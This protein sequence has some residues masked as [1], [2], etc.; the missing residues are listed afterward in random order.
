MIQILYACFSS[1]HRRWFGGGFDKLPDNRFL[2]HV[3]GFLACSFAL[4]LC[5]YG[6]LQIIACAGVLQGLFW[7]RAIGPALDIGRC[8]ENS[9]DT[10]ERYKKEW[11]NKICEFM[12]PEK[13]WY[14]LFYDFLWMMFRYSASSIIISIILLN[15]IFL[16]APV[17]ISII[18]SISWALY[19]KGIVKNMQAKDFAEYISG[20]FVGLLLTI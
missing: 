11:W 13:Y 15:P 12:V 9:Q 2:Q 17:C 8:D 1:F 5:G 14:C 7:A 19:E 4:W 10:I 16:L 18:Y 3:I 6:Y 20:F